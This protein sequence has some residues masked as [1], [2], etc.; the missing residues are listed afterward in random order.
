MSAAY[1]L[2][3]DAG[4]ALNQ[5]EIIERA[6]HFGGVWAQNKYPGCGCDIMANLYSFSFA[7]NAW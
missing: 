4:V 6:E 3:R 1:Y 5:I 2:M 7:L